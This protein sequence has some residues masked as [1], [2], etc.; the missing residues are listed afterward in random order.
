MPTITNMVSSYRLPISELEANFKGVAGWCKGEVVLEDGIRS[1]RVNTIA[2]VKQA[3]S[4]DHIVEDTAGNYTVLTAAEFADAFP[5]SVKAF[6]PLEAPK[7]TAPE[8]EAEA[9]A[10]APAAAEETA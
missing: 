5:A 8:A 3:F 7:E 2:G 10:E 9:P 4:G 1:I 6:P